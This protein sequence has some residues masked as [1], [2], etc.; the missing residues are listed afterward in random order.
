MSPMET[1]RFV[2]CPEA[3]MVSVPPPVMVKLVVVL[4]AEL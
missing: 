2:G 3:P 4:A 1:P